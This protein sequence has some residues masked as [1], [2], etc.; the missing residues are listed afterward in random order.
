MTHHIP[1]RSLLAGA[2][3]LAV[4]AAAAGCSTTAGGGDG[5]GG[6]Q[7]VA[8]SVLPNFIPSTLV[9]PDL[10]STNEGGGQGFFAY[11]EDP[12]AAFDSPPLSGEK[13]DVLTFTFDPAPPSA[14]DNPLWQGV[15]EGLGSELN[16]VFVPTAEYGQRF[17]TAQAGGDLP[18]LVSIYGTVQRL[19]D[20]LQAQFTDLVEH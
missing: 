12:K 19:P 2:S 7:R 14:K 1:R 11:P 3:A 20:L 6:A 5:G 10:V 16:M 4:G 13:I 17:A 15:Q 9:E 18:D 8:D